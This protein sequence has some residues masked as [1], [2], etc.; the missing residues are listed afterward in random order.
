MK[1]FSR[2]IVSNIL[3]WQVRRLRRKNDFKIVA[4]AGSVGKTS[5]KLAIAEVLSQKYPVRYQKGNYNDLVTVPLIFFGQKQPRLYNPL[6]W[7]AVFWKNEAI[8]RK[9]YPYEIVVVELGSDGPGDMQE[10]NRYL[11]ADLGVLTAITPEHMEFFDDLDA[12][13][14]E[15]LTLSELS[16]ELLVNKDLCPPEYLNQLKVTPAT[17]GVQNSADY[18]VANIKFNSDTADFDVLRKQTLL[19]HA[20]HELVSEPQLLSVCAAIAV[21]D[22]LNMASGD[23]E[24]SIHAIKPVSGR[25]R[26]LDGINGSL[27][28]DDSYNASPEAVKAALNTLYRLKAP[29]K[30]AVLGNMNELGGYSQKLHE[31]I[32]HYCDPREIDLLVT[33]G[34]DANKFLAAVAKDKGCQVETFDDPISAGEFLKPRIKK[35]AAI[36]VKGS[37]NRVFAEE[38]VKLLLANPADARKLVRQSP[39]W[40][41]VKRKAFGRGT[42]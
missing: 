3:G 17:Y 35:N 12:V 6:A 13:A 11:R 26:R 39:A 19:L 33:I 40:L 9:K 8:L 28:I 27:I 24:K 15:E 36:L 21:G 14:K 34:S 32:G 20:E 10:F 22:Y 29:Q 25:M 38:T 1:K 31:E 4:V 7:L 16:N 5:T 30:I 41:K 42:I 18:R 37:Q 23:I 2:N